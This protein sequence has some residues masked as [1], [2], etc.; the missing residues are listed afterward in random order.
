MPVTSLSSATKS[1]YASTLASPRRI[2]GC[3][4]AS[5]SLIGASMPAATLDVPAPAWSPRSSTST[6][7]PR[8]A[9]RQATARPIGA[10]AY[11]GDVE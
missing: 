2:S 5:T 9:A 3:S 6:F 11:H 8:C 10:R 1:G 4:V 7:R